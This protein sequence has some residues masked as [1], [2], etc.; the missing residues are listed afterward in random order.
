MQ[1]RVYSKPNCVQCE[2]TKR[3]MDKHQIRYEDVDLTQDPISMDMVTSLGY[4]QVPVVYLESKQLGVR[5]WSGFRHTELDGLLK[6][7][8]R[9]KRDTPTD[10]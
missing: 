3:F 7:F 2:T 10:S 8:R 1:I 5:H 4:T 6:H 9:H